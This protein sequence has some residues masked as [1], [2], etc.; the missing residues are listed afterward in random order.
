MYADISREIIEKLETEK[1]RT[2]MTPAALF[3]HCG[4]VPPDGL[5]AH[6]VNAWIRGKTKQAK[7]KHIDFVLTAYASFPNE[8]I[9]LKLTPERVINLRA[10][11][12]RTGKTARD[13]LLLAPKPLPKALTAMLISRILSGKAETIKRD[14]WMCIMDTLDALPS[15]D[16]SSD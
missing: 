16:A 7:Q 5:K 4:L 1:R 6:S 14:Q 11:M 15:I 3:K 10:E 13:I 8:G 9:K 2:A 12:A